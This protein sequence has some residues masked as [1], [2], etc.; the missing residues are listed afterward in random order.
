MRQVNIN[1]I[2]VQAAATVTTAAIPALN[3]FSCSAQA[4]AV[5]AGAAGTLIMQASDDIAGDDGHP[6][7]PSNWSAIPSATI[8]V[9]GA[10]AFLIPKTDL[11]YQWVRLVYTNTG[12]G[13]ISVVFKALGE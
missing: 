4:S 9:S 12:T 7:P 10:G 11:C 13:T 2:P 5:G 8:A 3:L 6:G 1:V